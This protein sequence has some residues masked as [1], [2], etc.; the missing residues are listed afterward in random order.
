MGWRPRPRGR[1]GTTPGNRRSS[2]A[3]SSTPAV[4]VD[5]AALAPPA[6]RAPWE[7]GGAVHLLKD[8]SRQVTDDL[9]VFLGEAG[10]PDG[11]LFG[12]H[13]SALE[14][15]QLRGHRLRLS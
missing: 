1:L 5:N 13:L 14:P 12:P 10:D 15:R 6:S 4:S 9:R 3:S 2:C 8:T 7:E 11:R